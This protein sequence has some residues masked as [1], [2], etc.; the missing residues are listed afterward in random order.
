M[1]K[2]GSR[3]HPY[4]PPFPAAAA[5]VSHRHVLGEGNFT[6]VTI[7]HLIE[8]QLAGTG[9]GGCWRVGGKGELVVFYV[10]ENNFQGSGCWETFWRFPRGAHLYFLI[11][12]CVL[13]LGGFFPGRV[14]AWSGAGLVLGLTEWRCGGLRFPFLLFFLG[15][16][17]VLTLL[18]LVCNLAG[19]SAAGRE[20]DG[21]DARSRV[22]WGD[23]ARAWLF[24]G[25]RG[26]L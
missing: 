12:T 19:I 5:G 14:E 8:F 20:R 26:C 9:D 6:F 23:G 24:P 17:E 22:G 11:L 1:G 7:I 18:G 10:A 2:A 3:E 25:S 13:L 16:L 15:R 4:V 21:C